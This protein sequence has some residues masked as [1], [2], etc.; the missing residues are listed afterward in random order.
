[1]PCTT[2][3]WSGQA[4]LKLV[5]HG[6]LLFWIHYFSDFSV[7]CNNGKMM[8]ITKT[9][10]QLQLGGKPCILLQSTCTTTYQVTTSVKRSIWLH[11]QTT[12]SGK[13]FEE[14]IFVVEVKST[15]TVKFIVLENFPL[16]GIIFDDVNFLFICILQLHGTLV[17][18]HWYS[19][20]S[21]CVIPAPGWVVWLMR[22]FSR[23][24]PPVNLYHHITSV[25]Q[26]HMYTHTCTCMNTYT[27]HR[28]TYAY[29]HLCTPY[30]NSIY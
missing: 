25:T 19:P 10:V 29:A 12:C 21:L 14:I 7:G 6:F 15:K 20:V 28:Y 27:T 17:C 23:M 24:I 26:A 18:I 8:T 4:R 3:E 16:Y 1:M 30:N 2:K 5:L 22:V 13:N 11:K 9:T